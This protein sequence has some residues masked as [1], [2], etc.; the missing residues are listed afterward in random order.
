MREVDESKMLLNEIESRR[1]GFPNMLAA[2]EVKFLELLL[3][4]RGKN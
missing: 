4:G 2:R 1:G 3:E